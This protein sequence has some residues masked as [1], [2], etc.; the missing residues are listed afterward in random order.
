MQQVQT[1]NFKERLHESL[2][3]AALEFPTVRVG[4]QQHVYVVGDP[5]GSVYFIQSGQIK[6]LMLSP[7]GK[8]CL[9]AIHTAGDIFGESCLAQSKARHETARAMSVTAL[10]RIPSAAFLL[11]LADNSLIEGFVQYLANRVS[12]QQQVISHLLTVDCEHRLGETLLLLARKLGRP[13]PRSTRIEQKITHEE[14]SEM[15]GTTRPRITTFMHKFR[16]L[17]F[18]EITREH[19]L[20][21]KERR[22]S[23][24]LAGVG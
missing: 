9:L 4:K 10:K 21:I 22:L 6:L 14:L 3:R 11:H 5:A 13:D 16:A 18:V 23:D 15:V 8:E 7:E 24:Y 17:G 20:I 1:G 19:F 12:E 2:Q